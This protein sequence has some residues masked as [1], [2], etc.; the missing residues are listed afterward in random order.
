M[1]RFNLNLLQSKRPRPGGG[2]NSNTN[3]SV[4]DSDDEDDEPYSRS[5]ELKRIHHISKEYSDV[6]LN[7]RWKDSE[8]KDGGSTFYLPLPCPKKVI[9]SDR[10]ANDVIVSESIS[11]FS[12]SVDTESSS[13]LN[14]MSTMEK[15]RDLSYQ[16]ACKA[17]LAHWG[18]GLVKIQI[19]DGER[20]NED[21]FLGEVKQKCFIV[22]SPISQH[23]NHI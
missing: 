12:F 7:P 15:E 23:Q 6:T 22:P 8:K 21:I 19:I 4:M 18:Q 3:V 11:D 5:E 16:R 17:L 9:L 14:G 2:N 10:S 20:F 13:N 1:L